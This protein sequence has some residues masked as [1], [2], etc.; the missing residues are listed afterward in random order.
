MPGISTVKI[1]TK[2]S[3]NKYGA[4]SHG[5]LFLHKVL[6]VPDYLC[7]II[8]LPLVSTD[9][10][11]AMTGGGS[12]SSGNVKDSQGK[13]VGHFDPKSPL[14]AIKVRRPPKRPTLGP[15]ALK[16]DILYVLGC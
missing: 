4:S 8:G 2:R 10:Y 5:S 11:N 12:K 6:H 1:P 15:H 3:L 14:F 13:N 9:G 7:D 16:E